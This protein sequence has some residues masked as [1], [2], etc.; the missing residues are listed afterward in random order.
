MNAYDYDRT[1][2]MRQS[3]N[4]RG[5]RFGN[6]Y[7][8]T[9]DGFNR[10]N[11]FGQGNRFGR[12]NRF[13]R[14]SSNIIDYN[15]RRRGYQ[16]RY[17]NYSHRNSGNYYDGYSRNYNK[18]SRNYDRRGIRRRNPAVSFLIGAGNVTSHL[19]RKTGNLIKKSYNKMRNV[20]EARRNN[21]AE[22]EE[23]VYYS[24]DAIFDELTINHNKM[25][26]ILDIPALGV[27]RVTESGQNFIKSYA[28]EIRTFFDI[29]E[30]SKDLG[31]DLFVLDK[32]TI[33][34]LNSMQA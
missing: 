31:E 4:T 9:T 33:D 24:T 18:Y 3:R 25:V 26:E 14:S 7:Y 30:P 22:R 29:S 2:N 12:G 27:M 20:S 21:K 34:T 28:E 16:N 32:N 1:F 10:E 8:D 13:S 6:D 17:D 5:T 19:A 23:S 11:R 15:S